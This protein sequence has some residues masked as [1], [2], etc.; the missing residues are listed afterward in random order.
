[1]L[2]IK[3]LFSIRETDQ[4]NYKQKEACVSLFARAFSVSM[5][6]KN[7]I[8]LRRISPLVNFSHFSSA[9]AAKILLAVSGGKA[10]FGC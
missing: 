9:I 4:T 7:F 2:N 1:M 5:S 6:L 10:I 8:R 3:E